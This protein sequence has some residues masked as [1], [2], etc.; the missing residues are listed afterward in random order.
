MHRTTLVLVLIVGLLTALDVA[1]ARAQS[2]VWASQNGLLAFRTDRD[3]D[4][5]VF[6]MSATGQNPTNLTDNAGI[7][8]A[9]PAWSPDGGRVAYVRRR[10]E[11]ARPD[12]FVMTAAGTGRTRLTKT[13]ALERDP[14]WSPDGSRIVYASRT[15]PGAPLRIFVANADGSEPDQLTTQGKGDADRSPAWSPDGTRIAFVSDRDG[16]FPEL[17]VMN[18]DGGGIRRVTTNSFI[19]G[20][21][22]WSPDGLTVAVERCCPT[23]SSEIVAIDVATRSEVSL[24]ATTSQMESDPSWSPDGTTIAF[25]SFTVGEGN[26]D[27]WTMSADGSSPVRLTTDAAVDLSPDWQPLPTCT[28]VGTDQ[29]DPGIQGTDANDVICADA[30]DDVVTAGLGHDLVF[31][32]KGADIIEGDFGSDVLI[33]DAGDDTIDGGPD[34]DYLDGGTGIDTCDGGAEGGVTRRCES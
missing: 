33:G 14:S 18:A 9:Q 3:A 23:G 29:S 24:T 34:F 25:A 21:P 11:T 22:T 13:P 12:L 6:T 28:V 27:I 31:G 1:P 26:V 7:A 20:N 5:E 10:P 8:D 4:R 16:G 32:G 15:T 19:D 17:Y 2:T 30:G